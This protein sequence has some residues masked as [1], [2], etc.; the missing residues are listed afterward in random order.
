[1]MATTIRSSTRVKP[2]SF[3]LNRFIQSSRNGLISML[4]VGS[5][6]YL[7]QTINT[8]IFRELSCRGTYLYLYCDK[9]CQ[10]V[11]IFGPMPANP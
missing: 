9:K 4:V 6:H 8:Y 2:F 11:A 1:M 3:F 5:Y 10:F 7:C